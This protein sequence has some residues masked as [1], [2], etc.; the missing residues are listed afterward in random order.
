MGL[1]YLILRGVRL[2]LRTI[3]LHFITISVISISGLSAQNVSVRVEDAYSRAGEQGYVRF[4]CNTN[5][6]LASL[7]VPVK[8][9]S[10]DLTIDSVVFSNLVP[11]NLYVLNSQLSNARRRGFVHILPKISDDIATFYAYDEEVFRIYYRVKLSADEGQIPVDTFYNR[12]Y[13]AG[14]WITEE[15]QA[16]DGLGR[17]IRPD[18]QSGSIWTD[19]TTDVDSEAEL[20][21]R[22]FA[23][24]QN[25]P[26][27]FNPST[28]ISFAVPRAGR[29]TLEIYDILGRKVATLLDENVESGQH[30]VVW[31]AESAP[32]GMYFYKLN[33]AGGSILRKMAIIK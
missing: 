16:S 19:Q 27:P 10:D 24:E 9:L 20:I 15:I 13:D 26:N 32:S 28:T 11:A 5:V 1:L 23:L 29:V 7:I 25:F 30:S 22:E 31:S 3:L 12:F 18:F 4:L 8:L 6:P 33:H 2:R 17:T 14:F 21:P